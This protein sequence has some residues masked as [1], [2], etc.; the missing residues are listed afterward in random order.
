MGS[1]DT[2]DLTYIPTG[3]KMTDTRRIVGM[4]QKRDSSDIDSIVI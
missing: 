1:I 4:W 2:T 3:M